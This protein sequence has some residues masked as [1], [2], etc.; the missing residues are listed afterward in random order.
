[1]VRVGRVLEAHQVPA[2]SCGQAYHP[3]AQAAQ[4]PIESGLEGLQGWGTHNFSGQPVLEPH[5]PLSEK[6]IHCI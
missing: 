3:P 4:G 2:L 1:M 6:F 5:H